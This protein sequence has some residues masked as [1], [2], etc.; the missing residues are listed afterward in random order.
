MNILINIERINPSGKIRLIMKNDEPYHEIEA[1]KAVQFHNLYRGF[2]YGI[3]GYLMTIGVIPYYLYMVINPGKNFDSFKDD[4]LI[5]TVKIYNKIKH[6]GFTTLD[7]AH[8]IS[9]K[10]TK[11]PKNIL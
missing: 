7:R 3:L 9:T 2:K 5:F 1:D 6:W 4:T 10:D 8:N 11:D